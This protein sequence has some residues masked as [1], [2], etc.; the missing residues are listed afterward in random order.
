MAQTPDPRR[1]VSLRSEVR[2]SDWRN[3]TA[4]LDDKGA[5]RLDGHD[6]GPAAGEDGEYEYFR[7]IATEH[8][9][10]LLQLLGARPEDLILDVL[11]KRYTGRASYKLESILSESGIPLNSHNYF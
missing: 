11:E 1:K 3:L 4:Y 5:L 8:F 9:P 10:R 6:L 7:T 2:G